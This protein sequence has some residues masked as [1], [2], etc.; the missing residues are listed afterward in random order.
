[1]ATDLTGSIGVYE[2]TLTKGKQ[3]AWNPQLRSGKDI[4]F[5][6]N[7]ANYLSKAN[8]SDETKIIWLL[9]TFDVTFDA[10]NIGTAPEKRVI[11]INA[12]IEKPADPSA[13]GYYFEGWFK[14]ADGSVAWDFNNDTVTAATTLYAGWSKLVAAPTVAS[15]LVYDG[16]EQ[17]GVQSGTGYTLTGKT[18]GTNADVYTATATLSKGYRWADFT[19]EPKTLQF[20]IK[21]ADISEASIAKIADQKYTGSAVTPEPAVTLN[22]KT[23][24]KSTDYQLAYVDNK[25]AGTA[26]VNVNGHGNYSGLNT[27]TF[28]IYKDTALTLDSEN[29]VLSVE[30]VEGQTAVI[31][32]V[33]KDET[34]EKLPIAG[35][36][37]KLYRNGTE[38]GMASTNLEGVATFTLNAGTMTKG[39][40]A[41]TVKYP[42]VTGYT[43]SETQA[44]VT[45]S[46]T[47]REA[48][49]K[50]NA[51]GD[52]TYTNGSKEKI[53]EAKAALEALSEEQKAL[54]SEDLQNSIPAA[55]EKYEQLKK[56]A[57]EAAAKKAS[58]EAARKAS[59]EEESRKAS[60]EESRKASEEEES[61]RASEEAAKTSEEESTEVE[62]GEVV[63]TE[64]SSEEATTEAS[65]DA[66]STTSIEDSSASKGADDTKKNVTPI[67]IWS[68]VGC[69][70]LALILILILGR[71][72]KKEEE[73]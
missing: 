17:T 61:R 59:E 6:N 29:S 8:P 30:N 54:V 35:A 15:E 11:D 20:E 65:G 67:I 10:Q 26:T 68:C 31:K 25:E 66:E 9:K 38:A 73:K 7:D 47:V 51:I 14:D 58:E 42:G 4:F 2:A 3:F 44:T 33:L 49:E 57:E 46:S 32:V 28:V 37:V 36:N 55:E 19:L 70:A 69:A 48:L 22:G 40:T 45:V 18:K 43:A 62:S 24:V 41:Y 23:L 64:A 16:T 53:D 56:E 39:E 34:E 52:V 27:T 12:K 63:E 1:M 5:S 13:T 71:K 72:K 60:E 50:I 21:T